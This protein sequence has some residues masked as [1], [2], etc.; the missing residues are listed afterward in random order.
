MCRWLSQRFPPQ[1]DRNYWSLA[2]VGA[3]SHPLILSYD[4]LISQPS[5]SVNCGVY[6]AAAP[7]DTSATVGGAWTGIALSQVLD[8]VDVTDDIQSVAVYSADGDIVHLPLDWLEQG[9]L[10][11]TLND[12]PLSPEQGYPARLFIPSL[13]GCSMPRWVERVE[14]LAEPAPEPLL[15]QTYAVF[16]SLSEQ[17]GRNERVSL[18]GQAYHGADGLTGVEVSVD[19]HDWLRIPLVSEPFQFARWTVDW[20]PSAGGKTSLKVRAIAENQHLQQVAFEKSLLGNHDGLHHISVE[21]V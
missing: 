3:S 14:F 8:Q 13:T 16:E 11:F 6:C 12:A 18:T 1:F 15:A 21:V 4:D 7:Y 20:L 17:V 5:T 10:A 19:G 9:L 2:L